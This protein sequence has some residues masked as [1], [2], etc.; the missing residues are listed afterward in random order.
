MFWLFTTIGG[1]LLTTLGF[2][3]GRVF[4]QSELILGDKRR[5]Y[6]EFL[7]V[8]PKPNDAYGDSRNQE[9]RELGIRVEECTAPLLLYCSP[10][11]ALAVGRYQQL[12]ASSDDALGSDSPALHP[13]F[14]ETAKAHNDIILE[15]RRDAFAWSAFA[16]RGPSRIPKD[17]PHRVKGKDQ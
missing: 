12:L 1:L 17:V 4:N 10:G 13:E 11:V 15:M 16:F 8:C 7:R 14:I 2:L 3:F 6:E 9:Q 5:V